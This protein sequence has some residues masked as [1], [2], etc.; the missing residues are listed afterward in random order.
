M[1]MSGIE[2]IQ[3]L[4]QTQLDAA[5]GGPVLRAEVTAVSSPQGGQVLT[6]RAKVIAKLKEGLMAAGF[7]SASTPGSQ[8]GLLVPMLILIAQARNMIL[9]QYETRHLK[10]IGMLYDQCQETLRQYLE[11]LEA[12]TTPQQY[13]ALVPTLPALALQYKLDA[14]AAFDIFRPV[15]RLADHST[16][17]NP[18]GVAL[19]AGA[20]Q[21]TWRQVLEDVRA[22]RPP[23]VWAQITPRLYLTF[24][25]LSLY[26]LYTPK[27]AYAA[28]VERHRPTIEQLQRTSGLSHFP[29]ASKDRKELE[30]LKAAIAKLDAECKQQ[31]EHVL[32]VAA[33]LRAECTQWFELGGGWGAAGAGNG[34]AGDAATP[35]PGGDGEAGEGKAQD[36]KGQ[37]AFTM[38]MQMFLQARHR[39]SAV[40]HSLCVTSCPRSLHRKPHVMPVS[41]SNFAHL[42]HVPRPPNSRPR[43]SASS[44]ALPPP[45]PTASSARGSSTSSSRSTRPA[46]PSSSCCR[47]SSGT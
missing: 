24:W 30:R 26:D 40:L 3:D 5:A 47:S 25:S 38:A 1:R 31:E 45:R 43:R 13:A 7:G 42:S 4:S 28:A 36:G 32:K 12:A 15:L 14:S 9:F 17:G 34:G 23:E 21:R 18:D 44:R 22:M 11:F 8:S 10:L 16:A 2:G 35:T 37:G 39:N 19:A 20:H 27:E 29:G 6:A 33:R 41:L 46:S